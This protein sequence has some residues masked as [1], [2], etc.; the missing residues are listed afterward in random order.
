MTWS[1]THSLCLYPGNQ[2]DGTLTTFIWHFA[3]QRQRCR[4][5]ANAVDTQDVLNF[6]AQIPGWPAIMDGVI[7]TTPHDGIV[8]WRLMLRDILDI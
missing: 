6:T 3:G 8:D 5:W 2:S 4:T 1:L 7:R